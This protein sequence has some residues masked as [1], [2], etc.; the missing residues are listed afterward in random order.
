MTSRSQPRF[1]KPLQTITLYNN[2]CQEQSSYCSTSSIIIILFFSFILF[3]LLCGVD[4][5][6]HTPPFGTIVHIIS[7]Q[8]SLFDIILYF[9][10][11][12]YLR[13]S[14]RPSPLYFHYHRHPS[15]VVFISSHHLPIP[16]QPLFLYF[17]CDFFHLRCPSY[18][19]ISDLVQLPNSAHP[20]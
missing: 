19:F 2:L 9:I 18:S 4:V 20:S 10:Q 16:L 12:Y 1:K 14:S 7:W 17:R 8:S 13:P 11:P 5:R 3:P 15:Y 6:W